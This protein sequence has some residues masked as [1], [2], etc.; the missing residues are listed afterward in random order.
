M[1]A[2]TPFPQRN[3]A[4]VDTDMSARRSQT[5]TATATYRLSEQ[6]RKTSLLAGGNGRGVQ[7]VTVPVPV[8]RMHLV[9]VDAEGLARV[10]LQ[11][12]FFLNGEQQV[13][14][15]DEPP[16]FD[17]VP[18][19][20]ELLSE[21]ARNHQL[22]SVYKSAAAE[23]KRQRQDQSLELRQRLAQ[24]FLADPQRRARVH[25]RPTPRNCH[26][27]VKTT[28]VR[29]DART[30]VGVARQ[31]PPE[32]YRRFCA[33]ERE[34]TQRGHE[35]F[36][37]GYAVHEEKKRLIADWV[38]KY[39]SPS[40]QERHAAGLL[41]I[42]EVLEGMADE[43]F[44]AAVSRPRYVADGIERLQAFLRQHPQYAHVIVAKPE[45]E[46]RTERAEAATEA[47]WSM[48]SE[49]RAM[50]PAADVTLQRHTLTWL[51]DS[52]APTLTIYGVLVRRRIGPFNIR[53]EF[54][55]PSA[56]TSDGIISG[57]AMAVFDKA[58]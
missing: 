19:V 48:L 58:P 22:E 9:S 30:D 1:E 31:V 39:G 52:S 15:N 54:V 41:P 56:P 42:A 8:S 35:E 11:P 34:R 27:L 47:Q 33:D 49:L 51:R 44:A 24:E 14:R 25:P 23:E 55:A 26:V 6:G 45:L 10:R 37:R 53:R 3:D 16:I 28:V 57:D 32:A 7:E 12:R 4:T 2:V 17:T 36:T 13:V 29:F 40:Q 21:A 5:L 38:A 50:F 18:S 20:D 43:E 46:V